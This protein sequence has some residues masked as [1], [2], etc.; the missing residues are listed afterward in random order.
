MSKELN[1]NIPEETQPTYANLVQIS[2]KDDEFTLN[3][4]HRI[5]NTNQA[6]AKAIVSITPQHA[7]RLK[8]ALEQNIQ[9]YESKFGKIDLPEEEEKEHHDVEIA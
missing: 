8:R 6:N 3:F 2:H 4:L 1:V 7:K 5:P 9:K